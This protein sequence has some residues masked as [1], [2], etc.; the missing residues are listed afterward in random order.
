MAVV[1]AADQITCSLAVRRAGVLE[2]N[3]QTAT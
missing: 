1:Q 2:Q 3:S